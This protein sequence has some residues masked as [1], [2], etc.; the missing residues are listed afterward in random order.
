MSSSEPRTLP[1]ASRG[2]G[3]VAVWVLIVVCVLVFS[4]LTV[5]HL[6]ARNR[7]TIDPELEKELVEAI[8]E[9]PYPGPD[10]PQW[11]GPNRDGVSRETG[12]LDEWPDDG[13]TELW[14]K[15]TGKGYSGVVVARGR[16]FTMVQ[17]GEDEAVVCWDAQTGQERW[18][19]KYPAHLR[20][21]YGD[22]PRSTPAIDGEHIYTVGG[23]GIMHCLKAFT[24]NPAGERVWRKDLM[25][26]FTAKPPEWG[27]AFSPLVEK[28]LVYVMP[29]GPG[30]HSLAA[31]DKDSGAIVWEAFDDLPSYSSPVAADLAGKRQ[32]IFLTESRLVGVVPETGTL[33]WEVPW[34]PSAAT[35]APTNIT[36]PLVTRIGKADTVFVSSGYNKGCALFKIEASG[37]G[38]R[39][40]QVYHNRNLCTIF[41]NAV[42]H[43]EYIYGLDDTRLKCLELRTGTEQWAAKK[44]RFGKGSIAL[45]DGRLIILSDNGNLTLAAAD[46]RGYEPKSELERSPQPSSWTVPVVS[47]G[48]LYVRDIK[49]LVCYDL[50][51]AP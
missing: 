49:R 20:H 39:A 42:R 7:S 4:G 10:W 31:L 18:R 24:E 17:D 33:L 15:P 37:D 12:L 3:T 38:F 43:G 32:V 46:P 23:S 34:G 30:G 22:G 41:C 47:G 45:A 14:S 11:R 1:P 21:A 28:G 8:Q 29:G 27:V 36:T 26:E 25:D 50:K 2:W 9:P 19:F 48:R 13:P 5:Y 44:T 51:K 16:V 35:H 40:R 6:R